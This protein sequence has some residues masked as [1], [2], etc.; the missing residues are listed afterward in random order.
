MLWILPRDEKKIVSYFSKEDDFD[1][2]ATT[3]RKRRR[4]RKGGKILR[5]D[6]HER[7]A[8]KTTE[9]ERRIRENSVVLCGVSFGVALGGFVRR[10]CA[11]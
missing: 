7:D 8:Q 10:K 3:A 9:M 5:A 2:F 6:V 4:I 11:E 1:A